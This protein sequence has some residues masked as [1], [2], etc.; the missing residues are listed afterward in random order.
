VQPIAL[1]DLALGD[2]GLFW[3]RDRR[4]AQHFAIFG[5]HP[6]LPGVPTMIHSYLL[7]NKVTENTVD[8]FWLKRIL[9]IYRFPG[10]A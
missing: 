8:D 2:F 3:Y 7:A 9:K 1:N 4:E 6:L 10:V 5:D